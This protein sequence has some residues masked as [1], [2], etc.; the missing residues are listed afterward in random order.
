MAKG[1]Y[2]PINVYKYL[3]DPRKI[4]FLSSWE[5][6][7]MDFCDKNPNILKWGSEEFK[8]PYIHPIKR[9]ADGSPKRCNYFPDFII[10]YKNTRG[11]II[12]EVI[13]IKPSSQDPNRISKKKPT[14]YDAVQMIINKAKWT[15]AM[16]FCE[17]HGIKFRI[18]TEKNMFLQ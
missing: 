6:K 12:T 14:T 3:G 15:A 11:E 10:K 13:E 7:F 18:L 8:I 4:R 5:L 16:S 9:N 17:S 1:L 2:T